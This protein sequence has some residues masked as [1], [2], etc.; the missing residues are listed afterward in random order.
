M[1]VVHYRLSVNLISRSERLH[2][3]HSSVQATERRLRPTHRQCSQQTNPDPL[4]LGLVPSSSLMTMWLRG[5]GKKYPKGHSRKHEPTNTRGAYA[6]I[7]LPERLRA[8]RAVKERR[9]ARVC[10]KVGFHRYQ[11]VR[12]LSARID[13][14]AVGEAFVRLSSS[15]A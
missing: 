10:L 7:G 9:T 11:L 14:Q 1:I 5:E 6:N 15:Q 13:E 8:R 2:R 12:R 4:Q 3:R